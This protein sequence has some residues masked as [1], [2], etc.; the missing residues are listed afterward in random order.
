MKNNEGLGHITD[1]SSLPLRTL[2][3]ICLLTH[4]HHIAPLQRA[5]PHKSRIPVEVDRH[6]TFTP[7]KNK[8]V[9]TH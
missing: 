8:C 6:V 7:T 5:A 1:R 4:N 9:I 2:F 3:T